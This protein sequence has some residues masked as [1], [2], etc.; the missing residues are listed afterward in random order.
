MK[1]ECFIYISKG[2]ERALY[3]PRRH[4]ILTVLFNCELLQLC[5]RDEDFSATRWHSEREDEIFQIDINET[6]L[7]N[8]S[9][10]TY[11]ININWYASISPLLWFFSGR[12]NDYMNA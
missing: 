2:P 9:T 8:F 4:F 12:F 10:G 11:S 6:N 7:R 3:S 5:S 1:P